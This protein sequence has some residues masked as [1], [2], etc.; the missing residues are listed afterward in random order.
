M[1]SLSMSLV[2]DYKIRPKEL[3][4]FNSL[5]FK[6]YR[7]MAFVNTVLLLFFFEKAPAF[8]AVYILIF[9]IYGIY[10]YRGLLF[11]KKHDPNKDGLI[12]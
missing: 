2:L 3:K 9:G 8:F 10:T 7:L 5:N 11:L 1:S 12:S 4:Q 6:I